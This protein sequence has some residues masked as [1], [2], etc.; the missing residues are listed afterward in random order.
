[1]TFWYKFNIRYIDCFTVIYL[2]VNSHSK[3]LSPE[4]NKYFKFCNIIYNIFDFEINIIFANQNINSGL[5][6][7]TNTTT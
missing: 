4:T 6:Y 1:M 2:K 5:Q 3:I 7:F